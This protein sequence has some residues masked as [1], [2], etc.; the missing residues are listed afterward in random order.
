VAAGGVAPDSRQARQA[1]FAL[2][3]VADALAPTNTWLGNP[4]AVKKFFDTGGASAV[5]GLGHVIDDM[6]QN[7]GMPAQVDRTAFRVGEHLALTPGA[8]VHQ[9]EVLELIQ[10]AP[11]TPTVHRRPLLAVPPQINKFYVLDLA[12]GRSLIEYLVANG[13]LLF[14][15]SWRNPTPA[16]RDWGLDTY[17]QAVLE[18]IE[19]VRAITGS[20]DV[21]LLGA[22]SGG[23]TSALLLAQLAARGDRRV[24]AATLLVT[25]LDGSA[26]SQLG[27]FATPGWIETARLASQLTGVLEGHALARAFAWLRPNDLVWKYWVNNYLLGEE[28]PAFDVLHWSNDSTNLPA[29]LH[30]DF[31]DLVGASIDLSRVDVDA[32][33]L[34]GV[35]GH[36]TPWQACYATARLLGGRCEFVLSSS[37]HVQ[38]ILN[39]PGNPKASFFHGARLPAEPAAWLAEA[40]PHTGSWWQHWRGWLAERS[41]ARRPA[42][43]ALGNR[44]FSP[45]APAPGT[46]VHQAA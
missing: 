32:Y 28:P 10:Y 30:A 22:C 43:R 27:L 9:T 42:P 29:R 20:H 4:A 23:I 12:P 40:Q 31:L 15:L 19:A 25:A 34:A 33:V 39:P 38:R 44:R 17:V 45:G 18:A 8:V 36:L 5:R 26:E 3:Q 14:T 1:R 6:A 7:H 16:Q 11:A 21:N 37:G 2:E 35:T 24:N 41:G 46:Y 13:F